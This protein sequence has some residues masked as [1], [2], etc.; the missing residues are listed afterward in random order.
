MRGKRG[1]KVAHERWVHHAS[2]RIHV[3][4]SLCIAHLPLDRWAQHQTL[5]MTCSK[6]VDLQ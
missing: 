5:N 4:G 3:D 6:C 2:A 1:R